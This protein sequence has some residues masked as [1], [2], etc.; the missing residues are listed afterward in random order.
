MGI[1]TEF[2]HRKPRCFGAFNLVSK[3]LAEENPFIYC[4]VQCKCKNDH[5]HILAHRTNDEL[6]API[7]LV[8]PECDHS[9]MVFNPEVHGWDGQNGD[10][11][12]IVGDGDPQLLN[13]KPLKIETYRSYQ[14]SENYE[15]LAE[16]GIVNLEDYFDTFGLYGLDQKGNIVIAIDYECA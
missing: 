8:C 3:A 9:E 14:G 7:T 6:I 16:D 13:E 4:L 2:K 11:C 12:S 5:L 1:N 15:D 10:N